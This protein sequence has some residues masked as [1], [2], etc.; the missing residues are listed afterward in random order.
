M[1]EIENNYGGSI[2]FVGQVS[3][4]QFPDG[5]IFA[6]TGRQF[7]REDGRRSSWLRGCYLR[8]EDFSSKFVQVVS[9]DPNC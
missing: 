7:I 3:W 9:P 6:V 8:E 5:E 2:Y 4:V 1:I